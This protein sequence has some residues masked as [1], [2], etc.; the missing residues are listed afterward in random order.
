MAGIVGLIITAVLVSA[1]QLL[2]IFVDSDLKS[3]GEKSFIDGF[4]G[5]K[6][7]ENTGAAFGSFSDNTTLLSIVTG[8][9]LLIGITAIALNKI[10][11]KSYLVCAVMIVSGGLGNLIDRIFR[12]Y[13][14]D[15]I[16]V[17]FMN[18]AV[19]NFADI[20]VTVGS[21]MLMIFL[22]ADIIKDKKKGE[23]NG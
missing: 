2:K 6:Y 7:L 22:I 21:V 5:W 12:G 13:V 3:L 1:D 11:S 23:K 16:E 8:I 20:L 14:I 9:V 4:I 17:Q 15:Y 19:F 18:F 10:K